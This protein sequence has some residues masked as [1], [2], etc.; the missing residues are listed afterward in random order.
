MYLSNKLNKRKNSS[1]KYTNAIKKSK[2]PTNDFVEL[3]DENCDNEQETEE[4]PFST[5]L[6]LKNDDKVYAEDN[7][8]YFRSDVTRGSITQLI[9]LIN[10]ANFEYN[11]LKTTCRLAKLEANPIYLHITSMGGDGMYAFLAYDA[12]KRSKIPIY[13]IS[14]GIACSAGTILAVAGIKKYATPNTFIL[15]HQLST[16]AAGTYEQ[17]LDH[18]ANNIEVMNTI[19][20]IYLGNT[21]M[22]SKDIDSLLKRDLMLDTDKCLKFG[23]IDELYTDDL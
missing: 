21:K 10:D 18:N 8:I 22:K 9:K 1:S 16:S 20:K 7:H 17:I 11:L 15:I 3:N 19:K 14:E 13:T 2:K 6:N 12:I 4:N 23:I 5:L